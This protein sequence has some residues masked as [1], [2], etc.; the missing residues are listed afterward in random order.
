ME[1]LAGKTALITGGSSGIGLGMAKLFVA[2]GARVAITGRDATR[3][4]EARRELG[5]ALA[6][7]SDAGLVS[8]ITTLMQQLDRS[9]DRLDV[10]CVNAGL[11]HAAPLDGVSEAQF[12]EMAAVNLKG[13]FFTIQKALP[14]LRPGSSIIVTT[15]IAYLAA[16]PGV[17]IYA[18][19][20]AAQSSL[21][22]SLALELIPRGIRLN[23]ICPGPIETPMY[24]KVG[25]SRE[26]EA[27]WKATVSAKSP[28]GRWGGVAEVAKVALF[29][30]S[31]DASYVVG[32][33][34]VIDGAMS[35]L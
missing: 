24:G 22:R 30:A 27:A 12:D 15:S 1:R 4:E 7:R 2:E 6:I 32:E 29:L 23:G 34:I 25:L 35:I 17:S 3:L 5:D 14:L 16:A 26:A 19:C 11:A 13:A 21:I 33:E 8:D 31:E 10:L 28:I 9:F 18:A 20:K